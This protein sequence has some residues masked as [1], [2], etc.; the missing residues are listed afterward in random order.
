MN[1][2]FQSTYYLPHTK[3]GVSGQVLQTG[4]K[5]DSG[6]LFKSQQNLYVNEILM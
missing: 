4:Q 2:N 5:D 6:F 1:E 3:T